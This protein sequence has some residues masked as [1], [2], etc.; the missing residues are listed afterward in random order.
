MKFYIY[1]NE[2]RSKTI[3]LIKCRANVM[4]TV[5]LGECTVT[6]NFYTWNA[7]YSLYPQYTLMHKKNIYIPITVAPTSTHI[8][9]MRFPTSRVPKY[10]ARGYKCQRL[11]DL[12]IQG[13]FPHS[14]GYIRRRALLDKHSFRQTLDTEGVMAPATGFEECV[15]WKLEKR[16]LLH[17]I[18]IC[19]V[20]SVAKFDKKL[21][22]RIMAEM[23]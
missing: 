19:Y 22:K 12:P 20:P 18:K 6:M 15:A 4:S 11:C 21:V 13:G 10:E 5:L 3:H 8:S 1:R 23:Y 9:S 14:D 17:R 7:V 16:A 2:S